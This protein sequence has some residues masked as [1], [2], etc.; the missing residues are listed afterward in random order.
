MV[1]QDAEQTRHQRRQALAPLA[2]LLLELD[3]VVTSALPCKVRLRA[4]LAHT[5]KMIAVLAAVPHRASLYV[6]Y[7]DAIKAVL[8][9][10]G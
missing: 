8:A 5:E 6:Q 10:A 1:R 4:A 7:A 9:Q 2:R 3:D